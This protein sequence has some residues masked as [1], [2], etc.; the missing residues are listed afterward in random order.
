MKTILVLGAGRSATSLINYLE[1]VCAENNWQLRV[2]DYSM[3]LVTEKC[4]GTS[5]VAFQFDINNETQ[6]E[7]E[8]SKADI[9]ISMLPANFHPIVARL[10][11][12]CGVHMITASYVSADMKALDQEAKDKGVLLLNECGLD[13][14][15][16]HIVTMHMLNE[17]RKDNGKV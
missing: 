12:Q 11:V 1:N 8:I 4:A 3:E 2:G 15:I 13:P 7:E 9:V 6:R 14:G 10:C 17:V 16:D 5:A